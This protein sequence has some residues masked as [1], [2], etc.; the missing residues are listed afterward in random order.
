MKVWKAK[1]IQTLATHMMTIVP[2]HTTIN[3]KQA[4]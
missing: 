2:L 3:F 4:I 1:A